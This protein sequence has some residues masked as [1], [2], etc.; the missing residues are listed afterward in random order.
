MS[1]N[2]EWAI[3]QAEDVLDGV[4]HRQPTE[5]ALF[6]YSVMT[7]DV[8]AVRKNCEMGRFMDLD[9]VGVLSRNPIINLKYHFV[10]TAAMITRLCRQNGMEVEQ[11]YGLSDFYI[12]KLDYI[13]TSEGIHILHDK[14]VLDYATKM[15][16]ICNKDMHSKHI[17]ACKEYIYSH[18]KE[19]ITVEDL[20]E[21]LHV[22][23][24]YLSR[25]F[26]RE[27]G[28]SISGYIREEKIEVAKKLLQYSDYSMIDIANR[29]SFSSQSH[30]IQ[31]FREIVGMTPKKYKDLYY[32]KQWDVE[33]ASDI[34]KQI[35]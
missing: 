16:K 33:E 26:K 27:T 11:A 5:E 23:A 34:T 6:Y 1:Y 9:G 7:G 14:M 20:S 12:Q 15:K 24:G 25:Q 21:A 19:R 18:I 28:K 3:L 22:S 30:F 13:N 17:N 2:R 8:E 4:S 31:Q 10:I 35:N 32:M 29:L